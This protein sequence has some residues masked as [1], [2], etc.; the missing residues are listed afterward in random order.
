MSRVLDASVLLDYLLGDKRAKD[1]VVDQGHRSISAVS[2]LEVMAQGPEQD[3]ER[4]RAFL[5]TFER[6]SISE[7]VADEAL[8]LMRQHKRLTQHQALN[9]GCARVKKASWVTCE[10]KG[11]PRDAPDIVVPYRKQG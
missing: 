5:R 10:S 9:W 7:A 1:V 3:I 4:T 6:L 8:S 11:L 2:W